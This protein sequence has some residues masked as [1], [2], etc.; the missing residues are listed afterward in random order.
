MRSVRGR[1][2]D[3][4]ERCVG[5]GWAEDNPDLF[6]MMEKTRM[7]IYRGT[8][9]EEP[10]LS[11]GYLCQFKDLS[12][13]AIMLDEIMASP[14]DPNKDM[15]IDFETKSLRDVSTSLK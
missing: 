3:F 7:Y 13:K 2:L 12:I 11:S 1:R 5:H 8:E 6:A 15:V 14:K 9:P 4:E 10:V